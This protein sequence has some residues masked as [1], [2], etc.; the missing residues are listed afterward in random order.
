MS[1]LVAVHFYSLCEDFLVKQ[2]NSWLVGLPDIED[3]A[4]STSPVSALIVQVKGVR[5]KLPRTPF[6]D[7]LDLI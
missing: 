3:R 7:S 4:E 1:R 2:R 6:L 5:R